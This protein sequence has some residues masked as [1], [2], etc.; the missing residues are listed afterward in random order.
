[1][2]DKDGIQRQQGSAGGSR[3]R[4]GSVSVLLEELDLIHQMLWWEGEEITA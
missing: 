2:R 3:E 1:V 4:R